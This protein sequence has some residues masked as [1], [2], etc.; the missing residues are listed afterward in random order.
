M[1]GCPV[2]QGEDGWATFGFLQIPPRGQ[3]AGP[4]EAGLSAQGDPHRLEPEDTLGCPSVGEGTG[5]APVWVPK[6][7]RGALES[8]HWEPGRAVGFHCL[9]KS[10]PQP[11]TVEGP[12]IEG[13]GGGK[14][15]ASFPF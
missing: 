6:A 9:F 3:A 1:C 13:G 5:E 15:H 11:E 2:G 7:P 8:Q 4:E 12:E 14:E 10:S